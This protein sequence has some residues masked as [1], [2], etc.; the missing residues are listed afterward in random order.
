MAKKKKK[1]KRKAT[2]KNDFLLQFRSWFP[3]DPY[4]EGSGPQCGAKGKLW[5]IW[6]V[7][8]CAGGLR[9][10]VLLKGIVGLQPFLLP[11][12]LI[13]GF[14]PPH[15]KHSSLVTGWNSQNGEPNNLFPF[16]SILTSV[17]YG[18]RRLTRHFLKGTSDFKI[19]ANQHL[20]EDMF[21]SAPRLKAQSTLLLAKVDK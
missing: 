16:E 2:R 19:R 12:S 17:C 13:C 15:R 6:E 10:C 20:N 14:T 21:S 1:K 5:N 3:K 11:L 18:I 8:P 7:E 4:V 9:I